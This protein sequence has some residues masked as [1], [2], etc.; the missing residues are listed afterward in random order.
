MVSHMT[1][2]VSRHCIDTKASDEDDA[3]R[4]LNIENS[5]QIHPGEAVLRDET[6]L[7]YCWSPTAAH[8]FTSSRGIN[9]GKKNRFAVRELFAVVGVPKIIAA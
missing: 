6:T 9:A 5:I 7:D 4:D 1:N 3:F 2:T 8:Y